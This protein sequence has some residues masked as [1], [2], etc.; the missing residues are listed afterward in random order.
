MFQM[1]SLGRGHAP[2]GRAH[3]FGGDF[4]VEGPIRE[5]MGPAS[6]CCSEPA[7]PTQATLQRSAAGVSSSKIS[8]TTS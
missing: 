3:R 5:R 8:S 6:L 4:Q 1:L 7:L 2:A